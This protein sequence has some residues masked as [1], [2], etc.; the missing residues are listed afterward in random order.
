V[1]HSPRPPIVSRVLARWACVLAFGALAGGVAVPRGLVAQ[2]DATSAARRTRLQ[3][4][5]EGIARAAD[6]RVG[7]AVAMLGDTG[8]PVFVSP[9]TRHPMQSVYKLP[10]AMAVLH[11]VD[12]GR[13][14]LA[15]PV[16]VAPKVFV[17][18]GQYSPIRDRFPRGTTLTV[19]ELVRYAVTESDG[20]ACDVL[21]ALLGGPAPATLYLRSLGV[22][23]MIVAT[24]ERMQG[25][26]QRL[27]Y[28]NWS[29]P[30]GALGV[31]QALHRPVLS[32]T[33]TALLMRDLAE[34]TIGRAR[35]RGRLPEGT[36]VAHKTGTS[37][38][39]AGVTAA[40]NDIGIITLPD[41]RALAV[42]VFV[43]D[44]HA[45]AA[46]REDVIARVAR[47][48]WDAWTDGR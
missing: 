41:G 42:A 5:L 22:G 2:A 1:I 25:L 39:T 24:T 46:E 13:L 20:T 6:G 12:R 9:T 33:L 10:I 28:S 31:L 45:T 29:T 11:E 37:G 48:A 32:D 8:R 18:P 3:T 47:A 14:R 16:R 26:D 44:S 15:Q 38:T 19:R 35:L 30:R 21:L 43:T 17:T 4:A 7:I 23:E 34:T 40:T 36:V 27:Q